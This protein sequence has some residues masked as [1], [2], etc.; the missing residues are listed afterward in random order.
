VQE[1][2]G[3]RHPFTNLM[4]YLRQSEFAAAAIDAPFSIPVDYVRPKI[5][6]AL[7]ELV[8]GLESPDGRPFPTAHDFVNAVLEGRI[9]VTKKPLRQTEK[10]W[11]QQKVNVRSTLWAGA[12]G[13]AAMTVACLKLLQETGCPIWPWERSVRGLLIEA[14]PAAQ[15][16]HW[17]LPY[18]GYNRNSE[19]EGSSTTVL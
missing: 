18:Q 14:F 13:G 2:S 8:A 17:G 3:D 11:Q 7:L 5:H 10:Y 6:R 16:C 12:R 9:P 19:A 1:L 4:Q 15:L